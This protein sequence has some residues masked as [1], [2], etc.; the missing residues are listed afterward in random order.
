[1]SDTRR[2]V[3]CLAYVLQAKAP[4]R[5]CCSIEFSMKA[6]LWSTELRIVVS[7]HSNLV[8]S[9]H[10]RIKSM[11]CDACVGPMWGHLREVYSVY[12]VVERGTASLRL[13][14]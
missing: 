11:A 12:C 9:G 13:I 6:S 4:G 14:T 5:S 2:I 7:E 8:E 10:H 1:M 3:L